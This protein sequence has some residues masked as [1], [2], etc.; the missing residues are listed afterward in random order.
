[1]HRFVTIAV[2]LAV[3][4]A[5]I[6]GALV[7]SALVGEP[8]PLQQITGIG[9]LIAGLIW[10]LGS[11][12]V[13]KMDIAQR[14]RKALYEQTDRMIAKLDGLPSRLGERRTLDRQP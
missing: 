14:Q 12:I 7:L 8:T 5:L 6:I 11:K 9:M 1:M 3:I 2:P 4:A 13:E 10:W